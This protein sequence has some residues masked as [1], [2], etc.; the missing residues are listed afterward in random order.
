MRVGLLGCGNIGRI[1]ARSIRDGRLDHMLSGVFD[2]DIDKARSLA[3]EFGGDCPVMMDVDALITNA[4]LVV[5]AASQDAIENYGLR[6]LERGRDLMIMSVGALAVDDFFEELKKMAMKT[7]SR[8]YIPSG[9]ILGLDGILSAK[10][11]S[12]TLVELT[13]IKRPEVLDT[14][15]RSRHV[16]YEGPVRNVVKRFPRN[17][18]VAAT[19]SLAGIGFDKTIVRIIAD[20]MIERNIHKIR[21]VGEFG[22]FRATIENL[23]SPENPKTSYLAALS[24]IATLKKISDVVKVGN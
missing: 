9:A 23:P 8:I 14:T 20:P 13:T 15:A 5:E 11:R 21:V 17:I 22:E 10:Q 1:I 24:A 7:N 16:L 6:V 3:D 2:K 18:N 4:D 12:I 19:L